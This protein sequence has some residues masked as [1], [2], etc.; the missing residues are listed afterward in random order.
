[1]LIDSRS[2]TLNTY[3][4]SLIQ[5]H[6]MPSDEIFNIGVVLTDGNNFC[7]HLPHT[8]HKLKTCIDFN[9][10]AGLNYTISIIEDRIK[11][12]EFSPGEVS[13]VVVASPLRS[14]QSELD[15]EGALQEAVQ[16]FMMIKK[17]RDTSAAIVK[18]D[19]LDKISTL[20][21]IEKRAKERNIRNFI[22]HHRFPI[23]RKLID[24]ALIDEDE[25]PYVVGS[26]SAPLHSEHFDDSIITSVFT[27]REVIRNQDVKD[28]FMYVPKYKDI[29]NRKE[30]MALGWAQEQADELGVECL[31]DKREDAVLERLQ[32]YDKGLV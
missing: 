6:N 10:I 28:Q 32:Q 5:F 3:Q 18:T 7:Y 1:M 14:F 16:H 19:Y 22:Q 12:S 9:E 20:K 23:A 27:L 2:K 17:L 26:M 25:N 4:C 11:E 21:L 15:M 30:N 24:M 8:F 31:T 13:N 29:L